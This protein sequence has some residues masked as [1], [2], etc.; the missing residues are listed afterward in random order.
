MVGQ[1]TDMA[2]N[3]VLTCGSMSMCPTFLY[4]G[5]LNFDLLTS[6][7]MIIFSYGMDKFQFS[8]VSNASFS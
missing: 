6:C 7:A 8:G 2:K 4:D 3:S 5:I 1:V